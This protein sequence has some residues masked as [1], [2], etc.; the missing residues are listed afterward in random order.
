MHVQ[1][2]NLTVTC[3]DPQHPDALALI[4]Q[5][6][7]EL[8]QV[9]GDDGSGAF[10]PADAQVPRAAFVV[11]RLAGRPVGCGAIRPM[12]D[13]NPLD[14][15][16]VKRMFVAPEARGQG[17]AQ[18]VL[19]ELEAQARGFGYARLMLETGDRQHA[20]IRLYQRAGYARVPCYGKYAEREWSRCFGKELGPAAPLAIRPAAAADVP[21]I[22]AIYNDAVLN[23]TA[24]YD[25]APSTLAQRTAWFEE[26]TGQGFPV[27]VAEVGGTVLGFG[28]FAQFRPRAGYRYTV[29][30]SVYV[31]AAYRGR[32]LGRALMLAL[33]DEARARGMHSMLAVIDAES[34][35]SVQLHAGCGF[36]E[37]GRLHQVGFKFGRWLDVVLMEL[38]LEQAPGER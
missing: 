14:T 4:R 17:V 23:T 25:E 24:S 10:V 19:A 32:G 21:A 9:Y 15:A 6:S 38:L 13:T 29:E 26:R 30:H 16:E 8:A 1:A 20:A 22:L 18:A 37:A 7:A 11:A 3:V 36:A 35:A 27:L 28:T 5:L 34:A 33:I 2:T 31:D 12:A